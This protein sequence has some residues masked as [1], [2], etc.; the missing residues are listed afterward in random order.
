MTDR[1][2]TL[3]TSIATVS[4]A[5]DFREKLA[6]ISRAGY[7][8]ME[9]FEQ[10]FVAYDRA[11]V[12]VGWLAEDYGLE[13]MLFQPFLDF[14]VLPEPFRSGAF[15]RAERRFDLMNSMGADLVLVCSNIAAA[16]LGGI[17][18]ALPHQRAET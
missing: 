10:D 8:G 5:G 11:A 1:S 7:T 14:E 15:D 2:D 18:R 13:I 9:I 4:I 17:D 12:D 3:K 16:A 6:A